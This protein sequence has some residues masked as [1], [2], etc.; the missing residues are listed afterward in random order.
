MFQISIVLLI[1]VVIF[2]PV[3]LFTTPCLA[4]CKKDSHHPEHNSIELAIQINSAGSELR[5]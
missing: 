2:V 5:E 1:L 4:C 3:M